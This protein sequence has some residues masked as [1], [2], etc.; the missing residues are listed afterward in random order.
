MTFWSDELVRAA[1][2][3]PHYFSSSHFASLTPRGSL[4]DT[5][6]M[7]FLGLTSLTTLTITSSSSRSSAHPTPPS[8]SLALLPQLLSS[9]ASLVEDDLALDLA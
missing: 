8:S 7:F 6:C 2:T 4:K 9:Q 5:H 3:L 1:P